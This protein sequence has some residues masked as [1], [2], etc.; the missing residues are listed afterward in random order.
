MHDDLKPFNLHKPISE[1]NSEVR[2]TVI[3]EL[4]GGLRGILPCSCVFHIVML[5]ATPSMWL[6]DSSQNNF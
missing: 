6:L 1:V 5:F 4:I 2:D 3:V